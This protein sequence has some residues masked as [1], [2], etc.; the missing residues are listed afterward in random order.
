MGHVQIARELE[1]RK[2]VSIILKVNWDFRDAKDTIQAQATA[3]WY[4]PWARRGD[5][6]VKEDGAGEIL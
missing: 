2:N 6:A 5:S 3:R 4:R 1:N